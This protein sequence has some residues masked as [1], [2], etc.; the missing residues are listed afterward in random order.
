MVLLNI[1]GDQRTAVHWPV[2]GAYEVRWRWTNGRDGMS[3]MEL[4][5]DTMTCLVRR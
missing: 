5:M 2:L 1:N 4:K 3:G